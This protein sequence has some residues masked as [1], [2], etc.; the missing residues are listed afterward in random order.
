MR[1]KYQRLFV[2][3]CLLVLASLL[4]A[5]A[6][7]TVNGPSALD[8][9]RDAALG[10]HAPDFAALR[11]LN[12]DIVAWLSA[13][14]AGIS[15]PVLQRA[16]DDTYYASHA[17]DGTQNAGGSVYSQS[18]YNAVDF[19]D[20]VTVLYGSE[21]TPGR[22]F[23]SL[24][25]TFSED[26]SLSRAGDI[27]VYTPDGTLKYRAFAAGLFNSS[28]LL[29]DYHG[30]RNLEERE[31]FLSAFRKY[32]AMSRQFDETVTLSDSDQL[33]ILSTHVPQNEDLRFLVV[34]RLVA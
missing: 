30:F 13:P 7:K 10:G 2:S 17:P 25:R 1:L 31:A 3:L 5:C 21:A 4:C 20:P 32:H 22:Q 33:L 15:E 19:T 16:G 34:A 24:Q 28:H 27:L 9:A 11:K 18:A 14:N 23:S 12:P 6:G 26:G 29:H 8:A